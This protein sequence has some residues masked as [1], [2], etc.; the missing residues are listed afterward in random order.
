MSCNSPPSTGTAELDVSEPSVDSA[1][2][3]RRSVLIVDDDQVGRRFLRKALSNDRDCTYVC[4]EAETVAQGL[5][6]I[7][8]EPPDCVLLDY[9]LPGQSGLELLQRVYQ[10]PERL[11]IAVIVITGHGDPGVAVRAMQCGAI[12]YLKK[13]DLSAATVR[14]AVNKAMNRID[15]LRELI[16]QRAR[17]SEQ[18][19]ELEQTHELLREQRARLVDRQRVL[20]KT[21]QELD[22]EIRRRQAAEKDA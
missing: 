21:M 9:N 22:A 19:H 12:D 5:G 2:K 18:N 11:A 1:K 20:L 14:R 6:L 17:L 10:R 4:S 3:H 7:E 15:M 8:T 13:Q 16:W